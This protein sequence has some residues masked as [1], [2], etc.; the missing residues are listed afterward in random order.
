MRQEGQCR[1]ARPSPPS[2]QPRLTQP[3]PTPPHTLT[4]G[5]IRLLDKVLLATYWFT[6]QNKPLKTKKTDQ[7]CALKKA[8][9]RLGNSASRVG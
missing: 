8:C 9:A 6:K 4:L 7:T 2:S 1:E 5:V 3:H